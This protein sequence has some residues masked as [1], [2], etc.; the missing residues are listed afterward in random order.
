V[1]RNEHSVG[2]FKLSVAKSWLQKAVR[3][4]EVGLALLAARELHSFA[5]APGTPAD[6]QRIRTNFFHRLM[7]IFL[8]D[9][10]Q[11]PLW[12]QVDGLL[13]QLKGATGEKELDVVYR[14]VSL[15][16][17]A[18]KS[19][20]CSHA[21][22]VAASGHGDL[23][24]EQYPELYAMCTAA[25]SK[26]SA[27]QM[28]KAVDSRIPAAFVTAYRFV[29]TSGPVKTAYGTKPVWAVHAVIQGTARTTKERKY[30]EIARRWAKELQ[31]V[32]EAFLCWMLPLL[33]RTWPEPA[34]DA[35]ENTAGENTADESY[36]LP[37]PP[38]PPKLPEYVFD[39]HVTGRA[40]H[41]RFALEGSLVEN[42]DV[43]R[44]S[45]TFKAFYTA[46][47]LASTGHVDRRDP[48]VPP[49]TAT[50]L[51]AGPATDLSAGHGLSAG[52]VTG[53]SAAPGIGPS[54]EAS[55]LAGVRETEY[56]TFQVRA[57]LNTTSSRAD[58]YF[59]VRLSDGASVVVKGPLSSTDAQRAAWLSEWKRRH[60]MPATDVQVVWLVPDLWPM[61]V[62]LGRRNACDRAR[63]AA[64]LVSTSLL[65]PNTELPVKTHS[66]SLW[67]ETQV[68]DWHK[69]TAWSPVAPGLPRQARLDWVTNLLWRCVFGLG[70][71][72]DRN[73]V[74]TH[75][76]RLVSVD[77]D[78]E[79]RALYLGQELKK[80]R[81]AIARAWSTEFRA[82]LKR[83]VDAWTFEGWLSTRGTTLDDL[84][85]RRLAIACFLQCGEPDLF[86]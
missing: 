28:R 40:D 57:Q 41:A 21:R 77:E 52:P 65:P 1:F 56:F 60:M 39:M 67:P 5:R 23:A 30:G 37:L 27:E 74:L 8:E 25:P 73:F 69:L 55:V 3:R 18:P 85:R 14:W 58:V 46:L 16:C 44:V 64:F 53:L 36:P 9:V 6:R 19:R 4:G 61:G 59:A 12:P 84:A 32:K 72:A 42:E 80:T 31:G 24:A 86:T 10:G 50:G 76:G 47:K 26:P 71:L 70:D 81:A 17:R 82:E 29:E 43:R 75:E 13:Q 11:E 33:A 51:S 49:A 2:G 20:A 34:G 66:S 15:M 62:P 83:A 48:H 7:I 22:A 68:V 63:P 78:G 79:P 35:G 38:L 54:T 45:P